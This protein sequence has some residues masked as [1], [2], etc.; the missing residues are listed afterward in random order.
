MTN[1]IK[2][3]PKIKSVGGRFDFDY[4]RDLAK[5]DPEAFEAARE[6][7]INQHIEAISDDHTQ[8]RL[9]R[10]QWRVEMERKRSK[11]SMDSAVRIYDM[12]WESVGKNFDALQDLSNQLSPTDKR[13]MKKTS[14][15]KILRFKQ[16]D[17]MAC[18]AN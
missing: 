18:T 4:W 7:K 16:E 15:A 14:E 13:P 11:N 12:M 2:D 3:L 10:L 9:R 6:A 5:K 8:D 17:E 1:K